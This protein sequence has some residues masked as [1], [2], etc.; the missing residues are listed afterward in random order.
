MRKVKKHIG[1][2]IILI[3]LIAF[4]TS[5]S[6]QTKI[7][8]RVIVTGIAVDKSGDEF[9]VTAQ[10]VKPSV[11][12]KTAGGG[13]SIDYISDKGK[14][15]SGAVSKMA[16]KAGK[17]SAFSHTNFVILGKDMLQEDVT[18]SLDYFIRD[19]IIKNSA[20]ILFSE[21]KASDEMKKTKN[22]DQSVGMGLQK[23]FLF[24]EHE[25]DGLMTT[26]MEFLNQ[27]RGL[28]KT[29]T[30]SVLSLKTNEE[31]MQE[32]GG[33]SGGSSSG[34]SGGSSSSSSGGSSGGSGE[35]S[36]GSESQSSGGE[37]GS[38]SGSGS[39]GE[40]QSSGSG[41]GS[42]GESQN[43]Y[44]VAESPI[45]MFV[46]G[47][48]SGKLESHE[49]I[50][51]FMLTN[52]ESQAM[53][54]MVESSDEGRLKNAKIEVN[55]KNMRSKKK[56]T[57]E[58]DKPCMNIKVKIYNAEINEI[59]CDEIV[60]SLDEKEY[61]TLKNDLKNEIKKRVTACFN[62]SKEAG[63]DI[64]EAYEMAYRLHYKKTT[65]KY[66]SMEEFLNDLILNVDVDIRKLDY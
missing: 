65:S 60:A 7:N 61:E 41:G 52:K 53:D 4:P 55:V 35:S 13:A 28:S 30:V 10:I 40:S 39:G 48:F 34:S 32:S 46:D 1:L 3:I 24:K 9:E 42:G 5:L 64:F 23:V 33:S 66:N 47:K 27:N 51:G 16:F 8:M 20:L 17:A 19:K 57:F 38:G 50:S 12:S 25:S 62:K 45:L 44:F 14:T 15:L 11:G 22:T 6:N 21:E 58:G 54:I 36:S 2:I 18:E 63:A 56:V 59:L 26:T 31:S 49:E 43:Q 29:A 37:S